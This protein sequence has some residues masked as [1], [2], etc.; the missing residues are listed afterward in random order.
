MGL[1]YLYLGCKISY[2]YEKD[3][4]LILTKF[5]EKLG[6]LNITLKKEV[7]PEVFQNRSI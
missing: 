1:L 5:T 7:S 3:I 4:Q 6:N 2:E